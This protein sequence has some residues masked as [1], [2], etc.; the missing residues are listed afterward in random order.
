VSRP[1][2]VIGTWGKIRRVQKG[3]KLWVAYARYRDHDGITR[4]FERTDTTA[5][6]AED[7]LKTALRDRLKLDSEDISEASRL[8][9][10]AE[11]WFADEVDGHRAENTVSLYRSVLDRVVLPG[12]GENRLGELSVAKLDR[13]L[14]LVSTSRGPGTARTAKTVLSGALAYAA[15]KGALEHNLLRDVSTIRQNTKE[16]RVLTLEQMLDVRARMYANKLAVNRDLVEPVD[17]MLATGVRIGEALAMRWFDLDLDAET[18][19]AIVRATVVN[20]KIQERPKRESSRRSLKLPRWAVTM[21]KARFERMPA[22]DL[23]LV[24]PSDRGTVRDQSN[25]RRQWRQLR[26]AIG[27]DWVIPHTF[28]KSIATL[29]D[30]PELAAQQ[31]GHA[32]SSTTRLHYIPKTHQGPDLTGVLDQLARPSFTHR[33]AREKPGTAGMHRDQSDTETA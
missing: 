14:K 18:P 17:F 4:L 24:F 5:Q 9:V 31:L 10:A 27:Y 2:L 15:R 8:S 20:G 25:M 12:L 22:N 30:D 16:V 26:E 6:R 29:A 11:G 3:P 33:N 1:P 28:R 21:L 32:S 7:A 13:F 23:D 19:T